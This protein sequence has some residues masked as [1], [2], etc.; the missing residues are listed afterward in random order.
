MDEAQE[1]LYKWHKYTNRGITVREFSTLMKKSINWSDRQL[2]SMDKFGIALCKWETRGDKYTKV[3]Y[4]SGWLK[5][6]CI[7]IEL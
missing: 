1:Q 5:D 2:V 6:R 7:T 3:Y 4:P